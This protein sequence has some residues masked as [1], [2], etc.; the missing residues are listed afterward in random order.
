MCRKSSE[1]ETVI[2]TSNFSFP[3]HPGL[4][5]PTVTSFWLIAVENQN[6]NSRIQKMKRAQSMIKNQTKIENNFDE[7]N[8]FN[9]DK[10]I[11]KKK[12]KEFENKEKT[13]KTMK[14]ILQNEK[15][16]DLNLIV[17]P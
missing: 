8:H 3:F 11:Y 13:K 6:Q 4:L 9:I 15:I 7:K 2:N 12:K 17:E 14:S 1:I 16:F 10:N 5:I